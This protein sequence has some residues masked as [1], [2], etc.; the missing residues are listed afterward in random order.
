LAPLGDIYVIVEPILVQCC[1]ADAES[2]GYTSDIERHL[3]GRMGFGD[4]EVIA[5]TLTQLI[6]NA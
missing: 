2:G 6:A 5:E 1:G 3:R 4:R